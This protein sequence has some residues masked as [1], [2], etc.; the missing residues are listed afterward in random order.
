MGNKGK[1]FVSQLIKNLI[2]DLPLRFGGG[3]PITE[4]TWD[5]SC[6]QLV[7][8]SWLLLNI[9]HNWASVYLAL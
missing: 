7:L 5:A 8:L 4:F 3:A 2:P 6:W 1:L 9:G